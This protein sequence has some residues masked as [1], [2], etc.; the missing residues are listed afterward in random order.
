MSPPSTS[1]RVLPSIYLDNQAT[2]PTDPR[3]V[4]AMAPYWNERFGNPHSTSHAYGWDAADAVDRAREQ[5]ADLIGADAKEIIITSGATES[6]NLAIKGA[7]R[8]YRQRGR[9]HLVTIATEHKCVLES[10][11]DLE[12]EG[13]RVTYL[14]VDQSG[15]VA[16]DRLEE[17]LTDE[18]A[19]VSAMAANNEIGV[20]QP[21]A[22]I[23]ALCR[24]R[25]IVFHTDAAQAVGKVPVDVEAMNIDLLSLSGHKIYG[26]MGIGVLFVRR[27][28][29]VRLLPILSGGGQ[30]R[31]LRSGTLPTPLCVGL[32]AACSIARAEI[33]EEAARLRSLRDRLFDSL[34]EKIDSVA[35]NGD[36]AARLPANLNISFAGV[37]AEDL[38][39]AAPE[40]ALSTGSACTSAAIE[41]SYVLRAL[42][43][44]DDRAHGSIRFGLGR[45]TTEREIDAAIDILVRA[46]DSVRGSKGRSAVAAP[47]L[48]NTV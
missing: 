42:G 46:V 40:L 18:T 48:G 29:R 38:M 25:G 23:S 21:I 36:Y 3:V 27:R 7:A 34:C 2:T 31:G 5:V 20:L 19:L 24:A 9:T 47:N 4:E 1:N 41:P 8:F 6:N 26:P 14:P 33:T 28:P 11:R 13:F 10:C 35:L 30:E 44:P 43:L 37:A 16:L 15:L 22:E 12:A 17:S 39:V 45:F 32:G